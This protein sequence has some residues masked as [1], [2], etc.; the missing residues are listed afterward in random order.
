MTCPPGVYACYNNWS[1]KYFFLD[2][3]LECTSKSNKLYLDVFQ[4]VLSKLI[5]RNDVKY[6]V[7][8]W[9]FQKA[10]TTRFSIEVV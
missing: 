9:Y 6:D 8:R 10:E 5:D 7:N 1:G 4:R 3:I 2:L